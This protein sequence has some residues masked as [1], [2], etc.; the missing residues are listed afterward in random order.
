MRR[1]FTLVEM[2][3]AVF[4]LTAILFAIGRIFTTARGVAS[5]GE[6]SADVLQ[7]ATVIREQLQR[8]LDRINRDGYMAIQCVAVR[9]DVNRTSSPAAPLLNPQ[10]PPSAILRC[11]Q[12]VFFTSG[13]EISA[14]WA[15]PGD[16]ATAGGGQQSRAARVY[17]GH[18][19]QLPGLLNDP[20][21]TSGNSPHTNRVRPI[22]KGITPPPPGGA[23]A[24]SITPWTWTDP[25]APQ[26]YRLAWQYGSSNEASPGALRISPNQPEARAWVLARKAVL[27]AD[28]GGRALYFPDPVYPGA[29]TLADNLGASSASSIF[30]DGSYAAPAA[31]VSGSPDTESAYL[32]IRDRNRV[33]ASA[34][35]RPHPFLQ[36]GWVDIA[37]SDIGKVRRVVA[38]NLRLAS[39]VALCG[40]N[41]YLSTIVT[42]WSV[43]GIN[44]AP[45][46]WPAGTSAPQW[47]SNSLITV[48][49]SNSDGVSVGAYTSQRDRIM[50]GTFGVPA[51]GSVNLPAA[52]GPPCGLLGW[53]RAEKYVPNTDRKSE[54]LASATVATNCSSFQVDWTW[55]P[56]TGRQTDLG[57]QPISATPR[58]LVESGC[59][60]RRIFPETR[61]RGFEP[62]AA[63]W[64]ANEDDPRLVIRRWPW[65]GFPDRYAEATGGGFEI[66][67]GQRYGVSLAQDEEDSMPDVTGPTPDQRANYHMRSVAQAI[68]GLEG[69]VSSQ[70]S[71]AIAVK[72]PFG[73]GVPV[74]V[75]TAV[76]GFNQEE[77]FTVTPDGIT[78]ARDDYTPWPSQIRVTFTLHDPR[79]VLERGREFQY[80]LSIP[81][82]SKE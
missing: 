31:A 28:D 21:A 7:Q 73:L 45:Q 61:L 22:V 49:G 14:R 40:I 69:P 81:K 24:T 6:A 56:M 62:F 59:E 10:L 60:L 77:A 65:F 13:M 18:G 68:E 58:V 71:Q 75:Y 79:L 33:P 42:P 19:V 9:N 47:P 51:I 38:P 17:Y 16:L 57:G 5:I 27:L 74:R 82:R 3:V 72:A 63:S 64:L 2:L 70:G 11:D 20:L 35:L 44:A 53:P 39:P 80:V 55:E 8:D 1:A 30:G 48:V 29:T 52:A 46:S 34:S 37:A 32:A 41:N 12:L 23:P 36:S 4:L 50:R 26:G 78:V 43:T 15:G 66:P 54:M 67:L 25:A 76:F